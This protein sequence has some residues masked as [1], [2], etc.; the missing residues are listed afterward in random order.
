MSKRGKSLL[1]TVD[2]KG[3]VGK[4]VSSAFLADAL[5]QIGYEVALADGDNDNLT[6]SEIHGQVT[7][8]DIDDLGSLD[9]F[10]AQ[11]AKSSSDVTILDMPGR[12]SRGFGDYV[13]Q[14][15]METI[16]AEGVRLIVALA[17]A[18]TSDSVD[19]AINWV[20]RFAGVAEF[21]LLATGKDSKGGTCNLQAVSGAE[22]MLQIAEGRVVHIPKIPEV[23]H[24]Q[25]KVRKAAPSSY[26][27]GEAKKTLG[28]SYIQSARWKKY[29]QDIIDQVEPVG[30]W[31]T[32][33]PVPN[34]L[35]R[36]P[37]EKI[38]TTK[39]GS[40]I[41]SLEEARNSR[42]QKKSSSGK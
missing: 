30:P 24:D 34:P 35:A 28:L 12:S 4:S 36:K 39:F 32:G 7:P 19:G 25:F 8:V 21:L 18:E 5:M 11:V 41:A 9:A 22:G 6:I 29:L 33:K 2:N 13:E 23:L 17:I 16:K 14:I 40:L 38:Q 42:K 3:G 1:I 20:S 31:L 37:A 15:G 10:F 27:S 26:V